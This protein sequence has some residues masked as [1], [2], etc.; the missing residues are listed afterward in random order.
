[1][2]EISHPAKKA[3]SGLQLSALRGLGT[4]RT[5]AGALNWA[6]EFACSTA[7]INKSNAEWWTS[8]GSQIERSAN[9]LHDQADPSDAA[10][11]TVRSDGAMAV[12]NAVVSGR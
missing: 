2:T 1:M 11:Q 6:A 7:D 3:E 5:P 4:P 9:G 10:L 8:N 12:R